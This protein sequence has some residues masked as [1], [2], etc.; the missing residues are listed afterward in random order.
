MSRHSL[1]FS[2]SER[3]VVLRYEVGK[4]VEIDRLQAIKWCAIELLLCRAAASTSQAKLFP[5][6]EQPPCSHLFLCEYVMCLSA[7]IGFARQVRDDVCNAGMLLRQL[8]ATMPQP[9]HS[10]DWASEQS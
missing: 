4:G 10:E 1:P 9:K 2:C 5:L 3:D 6:K 7:R 8:R